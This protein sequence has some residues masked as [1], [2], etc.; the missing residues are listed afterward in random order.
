MN[1]K[2][3]QK[4][5]EFAAERKYVV[6]SC[7]SE[8][9]TRKRLVEPYIEMLGYDTKN[10][11]QVELEL[12]ADFMKGTEKVDYAILADGKPWALIEAKKA[13]HCFLDDNPSGQIQRY[14]QSSSAVKCVAYTNGREWRWY[15]KDDENDG[16]VLRDRP[17]LKHNVFRPQQR[18]TIWLAAFGIGTKDPAKG[19]NIAE[20]QDMLS[21]FGDW[22]ACSSQNP[23]NKFL[24]ILLQ[25]CKLGPTKR[26]MQQAGKIW[27]LAVNSQKD[28]GRENQTNRNESE[29]ETEWRPV[30]HEPKL[31]KTASAGD[32]SSLK[33]RRRHAW[34]RWRINS[35]TDWKIHRNG[36]EA[37]TNIAE[38]IL[39]EDRSGAILQAL[40]ADYNDSVPK[41]VIHPTGSKHYRAP[42]IELTSCPGM[43]LRVCMDKDMQRAFF[44]RCLRACP[45]LE[46]E[47]NDDGWERENWRRIEAD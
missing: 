7:K 31:P 5:K 14:A 38:K 35:L 30:G 24:Q 27:Q 34:Y 37:V 45:K 6:D 43:S 25:E 21:R 26:R 12:R 8:I 4:M 18:E 3:F 23:T 10:P 16:R 28:G 33:S 42:T 9:Q 41:E 1:Q 39:A 40:N 32:N 46:I 29:V 22:L 15:L 2:L 19:E 13:T 11:E 44:K 36:R 17:F 20:E 47:A